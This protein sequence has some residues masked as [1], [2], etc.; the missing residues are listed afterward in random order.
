[1]KNPYIKLWVNDYIRGVRGMSL[2]AK[3]LYM[4]I[5]LELWVSGEM[6]ADTDKIAI[7]LGLNKRL[8]KRV[9]GLISHKFQS[10]D[11]VLSHKRVT[12]ERVKLGFKSKKAQKSANIRWK[13]YANAKLLLMRSQC[14]SDSNTESDTNTDTNNIKD[15]NEVFNNQPEKEVVIDVMAIHRILNV[16]SKD[17]RFTATN[18]QNIFFIEDTF[19]AG[20]SEKAL[21]KSIE[22][23]KKR[24]KM[25]GKVKK[26]WVGVEK[27][28][29]IDH[30]NFCLSD[31]YL[32]EETPEDKES[33]KLDEKLREIQRKIKAKNG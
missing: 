25:E 28:F 15:Q 21:E 4:D 6:P 22:N 23:Y 24:Q 2:E 7:T 14:Y 13:K 17:I 11:G 26:W 12:E 19:R 33:S 31:S 10:K 32:D 1:M 30:I 20:F 27:F 8:T 29:N 9:F 18:S 5:I 3:G 16:F